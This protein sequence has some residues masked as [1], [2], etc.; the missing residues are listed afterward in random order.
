MATCSGALIL[1]RD[2]TI[3]GCTNDDDQD[4]CAGRELHHEGARRSAAAVIVK[5]AGSAGSAAAT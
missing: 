1:H 2:G 3:A 4:G 5:D